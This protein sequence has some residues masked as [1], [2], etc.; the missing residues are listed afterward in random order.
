VSK[1]TGI[2]EF[3]LKGTVFYCAPGTIVE[4]HGRLYEVLNI[5][6]QTLTLLPLT[7]I[8]RI[9]LWLKSLLSI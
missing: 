1:K 8:R 2:V 7:L 9:K 3:Y 5:S 6:G 4:I